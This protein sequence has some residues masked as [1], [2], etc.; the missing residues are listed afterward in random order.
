MQRSYPGIDGDN[1]NGES[2][3]PGEK[4]IPRLISATLYSWAGFCAA[5]KNEAA[6]RQE[7]SVAAVGF[8]LALYV[9]SDGI[10]FLFLTL[11]LLLLILAELVNSAIEAIV[12]RVGDEY[13]ELSGR[14]KDMGSAVVFMAITI[15]SL[16]WIVVVG[17]KL[18]A[19]WG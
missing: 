7:V 18:G 1:S 16:S 5:W 8:P 14:A 3:K 2:M 17:S 13:H 11:P 10:E 19:P 4:G 12:D 6:F 15:A 9:A